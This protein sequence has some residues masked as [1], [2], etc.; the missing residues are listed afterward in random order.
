MVGGAVDIR[1]EREGPVVGNELAKAPASF[2]AITLHGYPEP[3][4]E[5]SWRK[6]ALKEQ[7]PTQYLAPEFFLEPFFE[8]K[9]PFAILVMSN[10]AVA[11]V[12][13]GTHEKTFVRCGNSGSPQMSVSSE[14]TPAEIERLVEAL[15]TE[16][17]GRKG[18]TLSSFSNLTE[19]EEHGFFRR[20]TGSTIMLDLRLGP[21]TLYKQFSKGRRS[22][23]QFAIRSG[24]EVI[25]AHSERDF[26]AYYQVHRDWC[27]RKNIAEHPRDLMFRALELRSNRRLFLATHQGKVIA[28]TIIRFLENGVAEYA[29]NN[30]LEE[31]QSLRPN[32][33][34]NWIGIQWAAEQGLK[35]FSMGGSHP[36]LRHFGGQEI[37]IHRFSSDASL[38]KTFQLREWLI[39]KRKLF[40]K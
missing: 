39:Q 20:M 37:N 4:I 7:Y 2:K 11:A 38:L 33:L 12:L 5:A 34:L 18:S 26:D 8:A 16:T 10:D 14:C 9:A 27:R 24:V 3:A 28:G 36:Y 1:V 6:Y 23:I 13:T 17:K 40:K 25:E 29:A 30:S 31:Y 22:D 21:E 15:R 32:P 19:L 35:S